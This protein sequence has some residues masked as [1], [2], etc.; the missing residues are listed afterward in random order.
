MVH[1]PTVS[2]VLP[3]T[4]ITP[5]VRGSLLILQTAFTCSFCA[6]LTIGTYYLLKQHK[7]VGLYGESSV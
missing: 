1:M 3:D 7:L 6:T 4:H 2:T 5:A